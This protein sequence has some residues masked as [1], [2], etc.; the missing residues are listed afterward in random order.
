MQHCRCWLGCAKKLVAEGN[1]RIPTVQ[2]NNRDLCSHDAKGYDK[3]CIRLNVGSE[4]PVDHNN[5]NFNEA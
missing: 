2:S 3:L 4:I 5:D 1:R